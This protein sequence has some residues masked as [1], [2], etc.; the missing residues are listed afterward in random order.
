MNRAKSGAVMAVVAYAIWGVFPIYWKLLDS[1]P[2]F[3]ILAHR[4]L[5]SVVFVFVLLAMTGGLRTSLAHLR[6][7][8]MRRLLLLSTALIATNWGVF[9]WAVSESRIQD[10][11][12]GYYINPLLNVVIARIFLGERQRPLQAVAVALAA[13]GV[14]WLT[15]AQG[16]LPWVSL[17]LALTFCLYGLVRRSITV[18]AVDG[19]AIETSLTVPLVI[20]YLATLDPPF[21]KLVTVDGLTLA[22]I[23]GSGVVTAVPLL[24]FA[25]AARRLRFTTL[26]MIQY[27]APS[28]QLMCA[29]LLYDEVFGFDQIVTFSLIWVAVALYVFDS[30]RF[31]KS[32]RLHS[33]PS[34][35]A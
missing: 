4:I 30:V 1:V 10:A 3:E 24:A 16:S 5:W 2:P 21:G 12:L 9:I 31:A 7:A 6:D 8:R 22:L 19:L 29:V 25:G 35:D 27:L 11:S 18:S 15:I 28:L 14:L 23:I 20:V 26:G 34:S 32:E 17:V 13:A 33:A